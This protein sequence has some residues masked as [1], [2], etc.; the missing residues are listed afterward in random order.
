MKILVKQNIARELCL[1]RA[2][3]TTDI[4]KEHVTMVILNCSVLQYFVKLYAANF[5]LFFC[6]RAYICR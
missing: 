5:N 1:F 2:N 4:L 3:S 6:S